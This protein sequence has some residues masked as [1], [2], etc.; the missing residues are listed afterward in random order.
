M[1]GRRI[2]I[3][4]TG[5]IA[6]Y[7]SLSLIRLLVKQGEDVHV[8]ATESALNFVGA[9]SFEAL[10]RNPLETDLF[11][12]VSE[13][14]HVAIG[15]GA[16]LVVVAPATANSIAQFAHGLAPD[17]LGNV[18]L[19]TTAPVLLAPAMHTEMWQHPA[20]QDNIRTLVNRGIH[21]VGP[22]SGQLTGDDSGVGRMSEPEEILQSINA[23]LDRPPADLSGKKILITAGGTREALDPVRF[24]GNRSSGKQGIAL[25]E[26]A[27]DRGAEVTLLVANVEVPLPTGMRILHGQSAQELESVLDKEGP[28]H[29]VIIMAAAIAD[30]RPDTIAR[31]KLKKDEQGESLTLQLVQNPD[32]LKGLVA[33][34]APGQ[35]LIGF[36]AETAAGEELLQLGRKKLAAKG[37]D[38]LVVNQVSWQQGFSA[39][40]N[41]VTI[42][43]QPGDIVATQHGSKSLI[44]DTIL[45]QLRHSA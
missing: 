22:D 6:A 18:L 8:I 41:T 40:E 16:D 24:L 34:R 30:Y 35:V 27:R 4:V 17:L 14:R 11:H 3:G 21:M 36:A 33:K 10:S 2:V 26:R 37:C 19:T 7:K 9:P 32:L 42:L 45:D 13:V 12:E 39:D 43:S 23:L 31:S 5:G 15:Q 38:F 20:T 25:A 28:V 1:S 44:A 29:D